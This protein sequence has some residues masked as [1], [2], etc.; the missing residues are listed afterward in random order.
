LSKEEQFA[1]I[2]TALDFLVTTAAFG[3]F[4]VAVGV[5]CFITFVGVGLTSSCS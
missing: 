3:P 5:R 4:D 2:I 1:A